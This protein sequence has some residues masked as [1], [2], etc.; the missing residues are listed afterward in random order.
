[1]L[2]LRKQFI[3]PNAANATL[4][5]GGVSTD[6]TINMGDGSVADNLTVGNGITANAENQ[7]ISSGGSNNGII[8][9][10]DPSVSAPAGGG[11]ANTG[12]DSG[13]IGNTDTLTGGTAGGGGIIE[14]A[15]QPTNTTTTGG[16][17][18]GGAT[19][20]GAVVVGSVG[21]GTG[22]GTGSGAT[23][24]AFGAPSFGSLFYGYKDLTKDRNV[25]WTSRKL[26]G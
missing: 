10:S 9:D 6:N 20:G 3:R 26:G 16:T 18:A 14:Q 19:G 17:T 11:A 24:D 23:S 8:S 7:T 1:M 22:T 5:G 4:T 15:S 12:S 2:E 13:V 21:S 25:D